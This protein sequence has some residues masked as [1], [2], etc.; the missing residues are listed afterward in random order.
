MGVRAIVRCLLAQARSL[1]QACATARVRKPGGMR[2]ETMHPNCCT[3]SILRTGSCPQHLRSTRAAKAKGTSSQP[4]P[5][6][7][8]ASG[9]ISASFQRDHASILDGAPN[10]SS[11]PSAAHPHG[12]HAMPAAAPSAPPAQPPAGA[13]SRAPSLPRP[14]SPQLPRKLER[15]A[16]PSQP[17]LR[18]APSPVCPPPPRPAS[19]ERGL[20]YKR[21]AAT[22]PPP[23]RGSHHALFFPRLFPPASPSPH[24]TFHTPVAA[25]TTDACSDTSSPGQCP[26]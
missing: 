13:L 24:I 2:T 4:P 5:P 21:C 12:A 26:S 15:P 19:R 7:Y 11:T 25:P 16:S 22:A 6:R 10:K 8:P 18:C 9:R 20:P 23:G 17:P 1:S 14:P 3:Q